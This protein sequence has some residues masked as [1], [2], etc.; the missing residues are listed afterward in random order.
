MKQINEANQTIFV[1]VSSCLLGIKVRYNGGHKRDR[2]VTDMLARYFE[3]IPICPEV[4]VGMGVPRE[5][6]RLAGD[7]DD[8]RMV[9]FKSSK[10]W[11][12]KMKR[13]CKRRAKEIDKYSISG[14]IFK[15]KSPS[16]GIARVRL[17]TLDGKPTH[18]S[19]VGLH[20]RAM[21]DHDP[22]L[23][24]EDEGRL[25]DAGLREN[26]IVRVFAYARL[27]RLFEGGFRRSDAIAFHSAHKYLL[28]AHDPRRYSELGRLVAQIKQHTPKEFADLYSNLFMSSLNHKATTK[29]NVNVLQ[30]MLG[31]F[32][33]LLDF[34]DRAYL[35]QTIDDYHKGLVP[36]VVPITLFRHY[37]Q[38]YNVE[39]LVN[40]VYIEPHPKELMLRNHT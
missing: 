19:T 4:E 9:G 37:V 8:P 38:K 23:P 14:Y 6:V 22:L 12:D 17:R 10:D 33:K 40:Q 25:N 15:S 27:Q 24:V 13:F 29:K 1:G 20:A 39:Y 18:R 2:F 36:L 34:S 35:L 16:C 32:K 30:H 3:F 21:M 26:F 11:T 5:S 31:F 7:P 28:M